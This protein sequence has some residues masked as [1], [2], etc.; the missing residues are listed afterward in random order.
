MLGV[1]SGV[2]HTSPE[3]HASILENAGDVLEMGGWADVEGIE[4]GWAGRAGADRLKAELILVE[5]VEA[6]VFCGI[7][8]G[9]EGSE[10]SKRS[11]EAGAVGL[12]GAAA[13]LDA[14]LKS[15]KSL[16]ESGSGLA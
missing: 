16:D 7:V 12:D 14:K 9:G 6:E 5:V 4:A 1:G 3:P 15:P 10:N 2:A 11:F 8:A 13:G